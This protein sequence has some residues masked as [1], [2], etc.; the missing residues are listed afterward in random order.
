MRKSTV[1]LLL[2]VV[3]GLFAVQ[4]SGET[5]MIRAKKIHTIS[6]AVV[7]NGAVLIRDGK[8]AAVG[9]ESVPPPGTPVVEAWAV[10]PGLVDIHSHVGVY[11]VPSVE[12]N[13]D[14]NE[15]TNPLT[16]QVR[17][18]DSFN[19]EDPAISVARAGGVTTI[20][21][22]PGSGN[23]IGGTGVSVK[24][25]DDRPDRMVLQED[26][27]LKMAIEGNPIG[28]YG[29]RKQMPAT[30]MAVYHL[31]RKAFVE[32]RE[33]EA[34][35]EKFEKEKKAGKAA[36]AP[37]RELGKE[38]LLKALRREIPVHM[39]C[40]TAAEAMSCIRLAR[41]FNLRLT[42]AHCY[43]VYLVVDELK[44][45][46]DVA[47]N[48]GPPMLF[49][50]FDNPHVFHNAAAILAEAGLDVSLQTD[51]L[52]GGQQNL[53][54][55]AVLC[56]R[57]G[58]KEADALKAITLN[59]ARAAGLDGRIGSLEPGK[60]ADLVLYDGEPLALTT[61]ITQVIIDGRVEYRNESLKPLA[62]LTAAPLAARPL[63]LPENI[64][65]AGAFAIRAGT[66]F[67][68]AGEPL[69]DAVILVK[70]GRIEKIGRDVAVPEGWPVIEAGDR[71]V[72]PGL[73]SPR[74]HA[75]ISDNWKRQSYVN[76]TSQPVVP[77]LEVKNSIEPQAPLFSFLRGDG[78]TSLLVT[79]G[80]LNVIGGQGTAIKS[81]GAV[82]DRMIIKDRAVMMFGLGAKARREGEMPTTRMGI[83]AL[84]RETLVKAR[85]YG[86]KR[87]RE[88]RSKK[89]E[90]PAADLALD[91]LQPVLRG[92]MP[93]M[94]HCERRDDILAALRLAD[95]FQ[96]KIILD[97]AT[98]AYK[99][100]D[101]IRK[102]G[103]P[104]VLEGLFRGLG[105]VEDRGFNEDNAAVLI[106]AGVT[107][108]FR[109][110]EGSWR[111]PAAGQPGGEPLT[112]AAFAYRGGLTEEE[113][114]QAVTIA[115]ARI[116]GID[117][118]VG[119]LEAGKDADL[120]ILRGHPF[121]T[122][123]IPEAVFIDGRLEAR[124]QPDRL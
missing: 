51:A 96:L 48:V 118:R 1:G 97:G 117:K 75:G 14:G 115:P 81:Y 123:A 11:S 69:R 42:L 68:L 40:A 91:A 95:E 107:V 24:L 27:C 94:I 78:I 87:D 6:G 18:L 49:G 60:D 12:E 39:H 93:V 114:L 44:E 26:N 58:M 122:G 59:G 56:A 85:E 2:A 3:L 105:H 66:V 110:D 31:A 41:E 73:V 86:E 61:R 67:T 4:A 108:A 53:L 116:A 13:S 21:A 30:L 104:V 25:K 72:M 57:R 89:T 88:A 111:T 76:E 63:D 64:G 46:K 20:V 50:Y 99:V 28:V 32:A 112:L 52:G 16:P 17:A 77:E 82:V 15:M 9:T 92:E 62:G 84:L 90:I 79:P 35:W 45:Y 113:A 29:P 98:D 119:S 54:Q 5:L 47:F 55:L 83:M 120:V 102:R 33:Y 65:A 121:Q 80:N 71:V 109:P 103:I 38:A 7:E 34:A 124:A 19:F 8:I 101:E 22:L 23:V 100:V 37:K 10:T 36:A 43:W 70:D 106:R 74:S